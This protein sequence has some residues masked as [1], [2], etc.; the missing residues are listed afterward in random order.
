[1]PEQPFDSFL[2]H[3]DARE[4]EEAWNLFLDDYSGII[5]RVVR[6]IERDADSIP[7]CFQFVCEQL[8]ANSLRRL[9]KFRPEGG[10]LFSTWL[11]AVVRNLCLDWRRKRFG[12]YRLFKSI[13]Q[14]SIFD[15]EV[16]RALYERRL[17]VDDAYHSLR[18]LYPSLT[19]SQLAESR[20]RIEQGLSGKQRGLLDSR[21]REQTRSNEDARLASANIPDPAANPEIQAAKKEAAQALRQAL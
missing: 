1:M 10:A 13:A 16:F 2:K 5:L 3:V 20:L 14:L 15:Q 18:A 9:R 6:Q 4:L 11:R 12:R 19:H 21:L 8:S 17:S 7:D